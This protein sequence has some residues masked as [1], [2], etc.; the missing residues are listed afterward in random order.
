MRNYWIKIVIG[1]VGVFAVGM[2][3]VTGFRTVKSK[4][5]TAINSNDPIPIPLIGLIPFRVD[6]A[7]LGSVSKVEFLR[8][9][10][11]HVSGVRVV[12]RLADS[13]DAGRLHDCVLALQSVENI[14]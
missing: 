5:T 2:L 14:N 6:S 13:I 9:D 8:S 4:V 10:P 7:K 11:E 12:V 3:L 1:A